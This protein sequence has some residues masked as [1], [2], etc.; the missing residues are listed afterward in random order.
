M[1]PLQRTGTHLVYI[2]ISNIIVR[3]TL[4]YKSNIYIYIYIYIY[5]LLRVQE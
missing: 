3:M 2:N 1:F 4:Y 5:Y